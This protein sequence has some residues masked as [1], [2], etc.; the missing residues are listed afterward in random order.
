MEV[1]YSVHPYGDARQKIVAA[2]Y[3]NGEL[4]E[5]AYIIV[6]NNLI[7]YYPG[8]LDIIKKNLRE[9]LTKITHGKR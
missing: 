1:K 7:E 9:V 3:H 2:I 5:A 4:K 8:Y 6:T